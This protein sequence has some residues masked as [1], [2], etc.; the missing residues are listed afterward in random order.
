M[1]I[2]AVG[3]SVNPLLLSTLSGIALN[4]KGYIKVNAD[5]QTSIPDVFAGGDIV[6]GSATVISAINQAK[7]AAVRISEFLKGV[8]A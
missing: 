6:S 5:F 2:I 8:G 1:G 7:Q 4:D 3:S